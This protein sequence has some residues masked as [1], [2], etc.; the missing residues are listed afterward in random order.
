MT[1]LKRIVVEKRSLV[2]PL[3]LALLL[4]IAVYA[5]VV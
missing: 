1:L 5:L 2:I 3:A 4:N